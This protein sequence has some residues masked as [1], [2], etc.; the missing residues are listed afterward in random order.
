MQPN[1]CTRWRARLVL[2]SQLGVLG[3]AGET[4]TAL[5]Q[6]APTAPASAPAPAPAPESDPAAVQPKV[7]PLLGMVLS[8][9]FHKTVEATTGHT[10][11]GLF[12]RLWKRLRNGAAAPTEAVAGA[13]SAAPLPAIAY[14]VQQLDPRD[15]AVRR[16]LSFG[17]GEASLQTG[18]VFAVQ[19]ST[20]LPGLVRLENIDGDG[21]VANLGTYVVHS[22]QL[23]R[24]PGDKGIRLEGNPGLERLRL[25]FYPCLPAAALARA[26]GG[27][28]AVLP[29]CLRPG[30]GAPPTEP[31][32]PG[33]IQPRAMANL[34]QPD[35]TMVFAGSDNYRSG[36]V[37]LTEVRI[38]H[39]AP[40]R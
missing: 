9:M 25:H 23:N 27:R 26:D 14:L 33:A 35:P 18:D 19:Y 7:S 5:A 37:L 31:A 36:E 22:D 13:D 16:L 34:A 4:A 39:E 17:A 3:L 10:V 38:R 11:P 24:L 28:L 1:P 12:D 29:P 21:R 20:S 8:H 32:A 30:G 2:L 40:G 6:D 15:F